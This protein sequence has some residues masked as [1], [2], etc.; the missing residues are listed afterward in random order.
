MAWLLTVVFWIDPA[1]FVWD[2]ML[3]LHYCH[4]ANLIGAMAVLSRRRLFKAVIYFW[5]FTLCIWAFLT[6]VLYV[7]PWHIE[8]WIFWLYHLFVLL[9]VAHVL[10]AD[11]F[12]PQGSDLRLALVFTAVFTLV[13]VVVNNLFGWN[14]GFVG[15][16]KPEVAT[17]IDVLGPYPLRLLWMAM[18]AF[19]LFLLCQ[20]PWWLRRNAGR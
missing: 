16:S 1:R 10:V 11:R 12:R 6:P 3:P 5:T 19:V 14:Y 9:A 7:G 8:F 13:L 20:L 15:P 2:E 18:L 17:P 4:L